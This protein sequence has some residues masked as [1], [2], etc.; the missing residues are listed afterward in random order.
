MSK[1]I[2][3]LLLVAV[4]FAT[5]PQA[6]PAAEQLEQLFPVTKPLTSQPEKTYLKPFC[7]NEIDGTHCI[8]SSDQK[9][10][11]A[12]LVLQAAFEKAH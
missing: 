3:S 9:R 8:A 5:I 11:F 7:S 6:D 1:L 2:T 4:A 12:L 10:L